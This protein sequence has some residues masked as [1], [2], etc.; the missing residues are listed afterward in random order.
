MS[1]LLPSTPSFAAS[2]LSSVH[3]TLVS[4]THSGRVQ[5]RKVGGHRWAFTATY[6]PMTRAQFAPVYG[7]VMAQGGRFSTFRVVPPDLAVPRGVA[8]GVPQV[9]GAGQVGNSI[10]TGGWTA[11]VSGILLAGDV[12]KFAGHTKVYMVT[13]D[14]DSD[15]TGAAVLPVEPALVASPADLEAIVVH[16]VPFTVTLADDVQEYHTR[17]PLLFSYELDMVEAL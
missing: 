9:S 5:T 2:R 13:V 6:P 8:S 16:D 14:V 17:A 3:R 1:G 12:L 15:A 7:F 4:R 10:V 11:N